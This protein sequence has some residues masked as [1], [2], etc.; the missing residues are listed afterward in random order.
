MQIKVKDFQFVNYFLQN[1]LE[2]EYDT[3]EEVRIVQDDKS[4]IAVKN[5]CIK[6]HNPTSVGKTIANIIYRICENKL[7]NPQKKDIFSLGLNQSVHEYVYSDLS[8]S[9]DQSPPVLISGTKIIIPTLI[10]NE[11]IEPLIDQQID[12]LSLLMAECPITDSCRIIESH[13]DLFGMNIR[14]NSIPFTKYPLILCNKNIHNKASLL[15]HMLIR[16]LEHSLGEKTTQNLIKKI[17]LNDEE[18]VMSYI[19]AILNRVENCP[20][21]I[22]EF[23]LYLRSYAGLSKPETE[24]FVQLVKLQYK[25][26]PGLKKF[27]QLYDQQIQKQWTQWANI[28]GLTEKQ[29]VS[30]WGSKRETTELMEEIDVARQQLKNKKKKTDKKHTL[31]MEELLEVYRE[32]YDDFAVEPGKLHE[33]LLSKNRI[34]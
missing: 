30:F 2:L 15:S 24:V 31:N 6:V 12:F 20:F 26:V 22:D 25:K 27:A 13:K 32:L 28:I 4:D 29:L 16:Q 3:S 1:E 21:F 33:V 17:L 9:N 10:I 11:I 23:I 18:M 19:I 8:P 5:S 14:N 7:E 34:W